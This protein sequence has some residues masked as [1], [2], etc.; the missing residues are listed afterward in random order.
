MKRRGMLFIAVTQRSVI[1][2]L[3]TDGLQ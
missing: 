1:E 3:Q 2:D